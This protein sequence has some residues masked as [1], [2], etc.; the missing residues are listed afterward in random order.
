MRNQLRHQK[1]MEQ[2]L[3]A[4]IKEI[5]AA[6]WERRRQESERRDEGEGGTEESDYGGVG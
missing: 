2:Q 3:N 5:L 1:A 6:A 4:T